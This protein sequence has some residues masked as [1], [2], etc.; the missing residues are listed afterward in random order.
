MG[1]LGKPIPLR[2]CSLR[3]PYPRR[4]SGPPCPVHLPNV[5]LRFCL[6]AQCCGQQTLISCFFR[7]LS[8]PPLGPFQGLCVICCQLSSSAAEINVSRAWQQTPPFPQCAENTP[9]PSCSD[10]KVGLDHG[11]SCF[12]HGSNFSASRLG[13]CGRQE[14]RPTKTTREAFHPLGHRWPPNTYFD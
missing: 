6:S 4:T 2:G 10:C 8:H 13:F 14:Q 7:P 11:P 1:A 12:S 3:G 9:S 5:A